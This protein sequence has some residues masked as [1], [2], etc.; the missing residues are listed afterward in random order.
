M[1]MSLKDI[2]SFLLILIFPLTALAEL[3]TITVSVTIEQIAAGVVSAPPGQSGYPGD[4]LVYTFT[5]QNTGNGPD[6]FSLKTNS[7]EKWS[8]NLVGGNATG[9]LA[10]GEVKAVNVE[11]S[12]PFDETAD[13]VDTLILTATS[14]NDRKVVGQDSVNTTVNQVAGVDVSIASDTQWARPGD[15]ITYKFTIEN[16][17]NGQDSFTLAATSSSGW[18]VTII[19]GNYIGPLETGKKGTATVDVHLSIPPSA[20]DG[21]IDILTLIV[22]SD[23]NPLA[24]SSAQATTT[25]RIRGRR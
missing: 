5:V 9:I 1:K 6:S 10:A 18:P 4:I 14:Q 25:I 21:E 8:I 22:T 11:V 17:G 15:T 16:T 24:N 3:E 19:G 13:T 23:L 7:S 12:I 2:I 20:A